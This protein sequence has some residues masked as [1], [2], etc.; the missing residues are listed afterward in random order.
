MPDFGQAPGGG[1]TPGKRVVAGDV[2]AFHFVTIADALFRF[3]ERR[4]RWRRR[5]GPEDRGSGLVFRVR[6][7][8]ESKIFVNIKKNVSA[9]YFVARLRCCCPAPVHALKQI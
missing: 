6:Y 3:S 4:W 8:E 9:L 7:E 2:P 1:P 5:P